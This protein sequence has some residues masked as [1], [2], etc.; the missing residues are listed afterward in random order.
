[1]QR[2]HLANQRCIPPSAR[3]VNAGLSGRGRSLEYRT[4]NPERHLRRPDGALRQVYLPAQASRVSANCHSQRHREH[5]V[6][7]HRQLRH[8]GN[9][10]HPMVAELGLRAV[11]VYFHVRCSEASLLKRQRQ[12]RPGKSWMSPR[13]YQTQHKH[14]QPSKKSAGKREREVIEQVQKF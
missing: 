8:E 5:T 9:R 1:M 10:V 12:G 11:V 2:F 6:T 3:R 14:A 13:P 4:C 7:L